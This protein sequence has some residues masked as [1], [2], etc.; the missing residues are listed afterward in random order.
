M[1]GLLPLLLVGLISNNALAWQTTNHLRAPD[2]DMIERGS[3]ATALSKL[4]DVKKVTSQVE[5]FKGQW[6][7]VTF[8]EYKSYP[9]TYRIRIIDGRVADIEWTR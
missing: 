1:K 3:P 9:E 2:G 8:Y 5:R 6:E 7:A 4:R